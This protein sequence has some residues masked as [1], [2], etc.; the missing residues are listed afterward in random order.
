MA[1][2]LTL[3]DLGYRFDKNGE[4]RRISDNGRF[5]FTNQEG[6][7]KLGNIMTTEL[8][9]ILED[10][11]GLASKTPRKRKL[12]EDEQKNLS[13]VYA[14]SDFRDKSTVV[15]I[16]HGSGAV[17]PGQWSRRLILNEGLNVGSQIPYIQRAHTNDWGVILC[18][19]NT[20]ENVSNVVKF[21][22]AKYHVN[23]FCQD[24]AHAVR[25]YYLYHY[26][27]TTIF[28]QLSL[29]I[30]VVVCLTDSV[31][32]KMPDCSSE[33]KGPV[34]INWTADNNFQQIGISDKDNANMFSRVH[35][36]YAGLFIFI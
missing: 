1:D 6:Y 3:K 19:T 22:H 12:F 36:I 16:I 28:R 31:H 34:F 20:D 32:F 27:Y 24:F 15:L 35:E 13:F 8:Y 29:Y 5:V 18:N 7:E 26:F 11:C 4:F 21:L 33:A 2:L 10:Q 17:R 23:M 25:I 14:S 30:F 9:S